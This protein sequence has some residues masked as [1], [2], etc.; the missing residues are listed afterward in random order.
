VRDP[1]AGLLWHWAQARAYKAAPLADESVGCWAPPAV[2]IA[3]ST[4][5][6]N[7]IGNDRVNRIGRSL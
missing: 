1:G 6:L 3:I 7:A 4:I 2:A 5:E